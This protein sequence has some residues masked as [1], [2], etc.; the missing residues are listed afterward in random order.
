MPDDAVT[1]GGE[2]SEERQA[3]NAENADAAADVADVAFAKRSIP[4]ERTAL[5]AGL[6]VG[7][8]LAGLVGW[9]GFRVY[10]AD[11]IQAQRNLF[12]QAARQGA[13]NLSTVDYE[14]A[15]ADAQRILDSATGKFYDSFSQ[16]KQSY[17]ENAK[18]TQSKLVGTVFEAGLQSQTGDLGRVL[19]A[20]AVRSSDPA[21]AEEEPA[22]WR[23][24]ITVQKTGNVGKVSD[25]AFAS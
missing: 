9:L 19:V 15:D 18:R 14:H 4:V 23:M 2:P 12:V 24:R 10:E 1:P 6:S 5:V 20:V 8:V 7:A 11:S 13:I 16:R 3:G 22:L 21:R 25:V 17:I